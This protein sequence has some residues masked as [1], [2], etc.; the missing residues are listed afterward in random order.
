MLI[1]SPSMEAK[2]NDERLSKVCNSNRVSQATTL[3]NQ[4]DM[5]GTEQKTN[6]KKQTGKMKVVSGMATRLVKMK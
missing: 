2:G 5:T 1:Y 4:S 3:A 6:S